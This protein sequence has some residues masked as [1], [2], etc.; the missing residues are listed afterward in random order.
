MITTFRRTDAVWPKPGEWRRVIID[1]KAT[2]RLCCPGCHLHATLDHEIDAEGRVTPSVD[3]PEC[4]YH[5]T[6]VVLEGWADA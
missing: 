5:E 3:C 4:S 1:G 2:A 6:G